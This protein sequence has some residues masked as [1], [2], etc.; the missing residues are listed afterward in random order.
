MILIL[1]NIILLVAGMFLDATTS[2]L[3]IIPIIA[4]PVGMAGVDPVHLGLIAVFNLML[5]LIT[6]PLGYALF[7]VS[8]MAD[9]TIGGLLKALGPYYLPLF[10]TL[11][12]IT[13][14]PWI[15]LWLPGLLK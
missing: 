14:V 12:L 1:V 6:P 13:F 11:G 4:G 9:T 15:S 2:I 7:L 3:L 5:G 10:A 8:K